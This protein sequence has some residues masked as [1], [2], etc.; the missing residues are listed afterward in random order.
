MTTAAPLLV[1]AP[2]SAAAM[3]LVHAGALLL[4]AGLTEPVA[5][6]WLGVPLLPDAHH[7]APPTDRPRRGVGGLIA[8]LCAG[9]DVGR[10]DVS[11]LDD[12]ALGALEQAGLVER[13]GGALRARASITPF[14]GA[15]VAADRL[16]DR[17]PEAVRPPDRSAWN[18]AACLPGGAAK[19]V[20]AGC[21]AGALLVAAARRGHPA[22]GFDVDRRA[23]DY[24][25][26]SLL[27][28]GIDDGG[29]RRVRL[30]LADVRE[31]PVELFVPGSL[32][33]MNAPLVRA[34]VLGE[35]P[36]YLHAPGGEELPAAFL[37]ACRTALPGG[38][39]LLHSQLTPSLWEL[40]GE[41]G[42]AGAGAAVALEFAHAPDGTP[43][44]LL[45]LRAASGPPH[46]ARFRVPLSPVLPHLRRELCDRLHAAAAL[47]ADAEALPEDAVLRPAPWLLLQRGEQ[48]DGHAFR[49]RHLRFGDLAL[50]GEA[51][52]LLARADGR[53]VADLAPSADERERLRSLLGAGLLVP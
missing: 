53:S 34:P 40:A 2:G 14:F 30:L 12:V 15:L 49:V 7:V 25:A 19:L 48:H 38:E 28:S 35:S 13:Q 32:C 41:L 23:L 21:G 43:H 10:A 29:E 16:D 36:L 6:A 45:S 9:Q 52:A 17:S 27:L 11:L 1:P 33:V 18:T 51:A 26:I 46:R 24:A 20:D 5:C 3:G 44:A 37:R 42:A 4:R 47:A 50:D 8:L 31:A 39:V 22:L